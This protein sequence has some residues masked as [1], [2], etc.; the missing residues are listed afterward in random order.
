MKLSDERH[1]YAMERTALGYKISQVK[2][3]MFLKYL[4]L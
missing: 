1:L 3:V 2:I 4:T